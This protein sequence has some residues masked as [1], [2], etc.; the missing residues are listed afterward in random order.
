MRLAVGASALLALVVTGCEGAPATSDRQPVGADGQDQICAARLAEALDL[1]L[2]ST[3][4]NARDTAPSGNSV[5]FVQ[6]ADGSA[7]A[8]CE[9]TDFGDIVSFDLQN[10]G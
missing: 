9:I 7:R 1:P 2:S 3:R 10:R 8:N 5:V 6:T 4:V